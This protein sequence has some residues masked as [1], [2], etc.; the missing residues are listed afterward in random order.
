[1]TEDLELVVLLKAS[2]HLFPADSFVP[3]YSWMAEGSMTAEGSRIHT[4]LE[5]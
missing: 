2:L 4:C 3:G 1:M 5:M